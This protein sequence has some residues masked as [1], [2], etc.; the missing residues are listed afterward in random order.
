MSTIAVLGAAGAGG[1][2]IAAEAAAR[3][4]DVLSIVRNPDRVDVDPRTAMLDGDAT[5]LDFVTDLAGRVDSIVVAVGNPARSPVLDVAETMVTAIGTH[6]PHGPRL[7]HMG[8]DGSLLTADRNRILDSPTFPKAFLESARTQAAALDYYRAH[9]VDQG[10][11]WTFVSPPPV[12]FEPGP[13]RGTYRTA[14]DVPVIDEDG[15]AVLSYEDLAVAIVDEIES[16][17]FLNT[18]FT[19]GY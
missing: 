17:R 16:S 2:R 8:G 9:A 18:R 12:H 13:R 7:L 5:D 4:H 3:G 14:L 1:R 19:A 11:T 6:T 10:V 15:R